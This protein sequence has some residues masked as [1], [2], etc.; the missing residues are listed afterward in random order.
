MDIW[1][2][3]ILKR[4]VTNSFVMKPHL[5]KFE[6]LLI[7]KE[8]HADINFLKSGRCICFDFELPQ[9]H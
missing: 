1:E 3:P 5:K 4:S 6:L 8:V 9:L 2:E 7:R